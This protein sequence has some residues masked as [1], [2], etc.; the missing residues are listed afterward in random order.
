MFDSVHL[1]KCIRNNW[2]NQVNQTFRFP[3]QATASSGMLRS[4]S[5]AHLKQLYDQ[6]QSAVVKMAPSFTYTALHPNSI[7]RQNV[8]LALKIFDEKNVAALEQFG[9]SVECDVSGTVNFVSNI[10]Q[11]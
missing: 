2:V 1:L 4:A 10:V 8:N 9:K 6:E 5:F 3:D 11:L 7:Q